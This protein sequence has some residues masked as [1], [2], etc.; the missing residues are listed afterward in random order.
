[1]NEELTVP[2]VKLDVV[3]WN[4]LAIQAE[5]IANAIEITT[6]E[7]DSMAVDSLSQIKTFQKQVDQAEDEALTPFKTLV[8]RIRN[9]FAP[10]KTSLTNGEAIIKTKRKAFLMEKERVRQEEEAKR[11]AEFQAKVAKEREE[12]KK[13]GEPAKILTPPPVVMSAPTTTRGDQGQS[14]ASKFFNFEVIDIAALYAARPDLCKIEVK[15]ADCL[16]AVATNQQIPGLR[17]FEDMRITA[18]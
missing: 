12:A 6:D 5:R 16:K 15:R 10:I 17:I 13:K 3:R 1:M 11:Q 7:E 9:T 4:G 18:R 2:E 14:S 8:N